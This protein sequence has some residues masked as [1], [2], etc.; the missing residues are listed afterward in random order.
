L[1]LGLFSYEPITMTNGAEVLAVG[2]ND[3]ATKPFSVNEMVMRVKKVI[4]DKER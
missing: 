4:D 1:K 3:F 2:A